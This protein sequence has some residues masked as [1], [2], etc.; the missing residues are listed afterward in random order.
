MNFYIFDFA[1]TSGSWAKTEWNTFP[2]S[3][4]NQ[5]DNKI[6]YILLTGR[7][8]WNHDAPDLTDTLIVAGINPK[9]QSISMLSIPR[10]LYVQYPGSTQK[11][12]INGI[13]EHNLAQWRDFA[14]SQLQSKLWEIIWKEIDYYLSVD[15][16][17]FIEIVNTLG[18][19]E[20]TL[21]ENFVDYE[22][23]DGNLG[24]KSFILR[25]W[26]WNLDGEVALMYARSRHSSS[27]FDRSLRQQ[28]ILSSLRS[29][30]WELWYFRDR[31]K[32]IELYNLFTQY[33]E[34]NMSVAN[35]V[36]IG[37]E[38][39]S[40]EDTTTASF[41]LNDSCYEWS[42]TCWPWGFL[43]L[44]IRDYFWGA[45]VL[46]SKWSDVNNLDV[47]DEIHNFADI[48]YELPNVFRNQDEII[49]YN[50]T[51]IPLYAW[52]LSTVLKP[53]GFM[54]DEKTGTQSYKE[55]EFENSVLYY[56]GIN[57]DDSTLKWL[58]KIL[59]IPVKKIDTPFIIGSNAR[60]EIFLADDN[61]F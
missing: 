47:F 42:L 38:I 24:Y 11:W 7:W 59:G 50:T 33:V 25:K 52:M 37:L 32:I 3:F 60:I 20:V 28:E 54:V 18:W 34:T 9:E 2:V 56:N 30:V 43:Y 26:T 22:Y 23:P 21:E 46:L 39:R 1:N 14:I 27:D 44:P 48:I 12:R 8:W 16:Q 58:Q 19:V 4:W 57:W 45:S 51:D 15:F 29:K 41:N 31:K 36:G 6:T 55:K 10:D 17:G 61:S 40:W 49:I 13:Y 53:Y 5:Q 35:M